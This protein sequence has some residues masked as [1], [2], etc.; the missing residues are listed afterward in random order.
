[1]AKITYLQ[2]FV[3]ILLGH[4]TTAPWNMF[5]N[6]QAVFEQRLEG[7]QVNK[8]E[9]IDLSCCAYE[10]CLHQKG[11]QNEST[12]V[13]EKTARVVDGKNV[14]CS[15]KYEDQI[16]FTNIKKQYGINEADFIDSAY[17]QYSNCNSQQNNNKLQNFWASSLTTVS[18]SV[19]L[20]S[21]LICAKLI[22]FLPMWIKTK[23]TWVLILSIF[24][25]NVLTTWFIYDPKIFF[26]IELTFAMLIIFIAMVFQSTLFSIFG[27]LGPVYIINLME[28]QGLGGVFI[29]VTKIAIDGAKGALSNVPDEVFSTVYWTIAILVVALTW[30]LWDSVFLKMEDY[31]NFEKQQERNKR[32]NEKQ[33]D[34]NN[35]DEGQQLHVPSSRDSEE[36][37]K[38]D[39]TC[40]TRYRP[41]GL[42]QILF[43]MKFQAAAV[44]I[45]FFTCLLLFPAVFSK[46]RDP[47]KPDNLGF[48][49]VNWTQLNIYLFFV[50]NIGD[51]VG[52]RL[53]NYQIIKWNQPH[54]LFWISLLRLILFYPLVYYGLNISGTKTGFMA[55]QYFL[56]I[57]NLCFAISSGY[58]GSLAMAHCGPMVQHVFSSLDRPYAQSEIDKAKGK[59]QT[60]MVSFLI[61]GLLAGSATSFLSVGT[62]SANVENTKKELFKKVIEGFMNNE[63]KTVNLL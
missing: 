51:W 18:L 59:A 20:I 49:Q 56:G 1:M 22:G 28:G 19:S 26:G 34:S 15:V 9:T 10:F 42:C 3:L 27:A 5:L 50:F 35:D 16:E 7:P 25:G 29:A 60:Y 63:A 38:E 44:F 43:A 62:I 47:T 30:V 36:M 55:T 46:V 52:K 40:N 2:Q 53:A 31:V 23:L 12:C 17:K 21:S 39:P 8:T 33:A 13:I 61:C 4:M 6:N 45:N 14:L 37:S 32:E 54:L 11:N 58:F 41:I 57:V 24:V 48:A